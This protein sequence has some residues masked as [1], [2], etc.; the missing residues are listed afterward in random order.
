MSVHRT[1]RFWTITNLVTNYGPQVVLAQLGVVVDLNKPYGTRVVLWTGGRRK[2]LLRRSE[3]EL[4]TKAIVAADIKVVV[5]LLELGNVV[6]G[7]RDGS[8]AGGV[9]VVLGANTV[10]PIAD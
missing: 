4:G 3:D 1:L 7:G 6:H 9:V 10:A 8:G 5:A 2:C